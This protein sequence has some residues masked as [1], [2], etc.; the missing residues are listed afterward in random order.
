MLTHCGWRWQYIQGSIIH[1]RHER[2]FSASLKGLRWVI[3][4][5]NW[6]L[7]GIWWYPSGTSWCID[8][9]VTARLPGHI[10][11]QSINFTHALDFITLVTLLFLP[12]FI[13]FIRVSS[14]A[15]IIER[16]VL[17]RNAN[18][19]I[20]LWS[21]GGN[22]IAYYNYKEENEPQNRYFMTKKTAEKSCGL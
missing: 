12:V 10:M 19:S 21:A 20:L 5:T 17:N 11:V 15:P 6:N 22:S 7:H 16:Q 8:G 9:D 14:L 1:E 13:W 4:L 2:S 18:W 3:D